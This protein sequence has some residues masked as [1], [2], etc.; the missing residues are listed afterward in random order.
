M[1]AL[2]S[3]IA[4]ADKILLVRD[5]LMH[6]SQTFHVDPVWIE[7]QKKMDTDGLQ[8]Q[9]ARQRQRQRAIGQQVQQ[10]EARMQSMRNQVSEFERQ[11]TTQAR[12]VESS[13]NILTGI[14]P[15]S[16]RSMVRPGV[17]GRDRGTDIGSMGK[18]RL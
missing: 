15:T 6:G 16:I 8:Y 17:C 5:V 13:G 12:R 10:F 9:I 1:T 18:V 4:A 7:Y 2:V 3:Y 14:T 11:Q